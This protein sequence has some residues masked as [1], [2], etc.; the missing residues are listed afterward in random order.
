MNIKNDI[1]LSL[2]L[3]L[4]ALSTL[5][6]EVLLIRV[7]EVIFI[8]NIGY[9]VITCAMF[10]FGLAGTY[11]AIW[12]I[13]NSGNVRKRL[14]ILALSFGAAIL[15]LRPA[16]NATAI[17]YLSF[18]S[19]K[20]VGSAIR[21]S[22]VYF[23]V[24]LPFFLSGLLLAYLFSAYS[25]RIRALYF[26]DLC[27]AALGCVIYI[28]FLRAI[29]PG[30]LMFAVAAATVIAAWLFHG[31]WKSMAPALLA[32][33]ALLATPFLRGHD[34]FAFRGHQDK[35]GVLSAQLAGLDELSEWDPMSKIDIITESPTKKHV[36]YD[37]GSQ[38]SHFFKFDGDLAGLRERIL[39]GTDDLKKD[40]WEPGVLASH[41]LKR[42]SAAEVLII[43]S[44]AGQETKAA[45]VFNPASVDGIEL[46]GTVVR[47]GKEEYS[48]F[49]GGIFNDPR[50]HNQV[51]EGRQWLRSTS[52]KYD[53]IQIHSNHT[54]SFITSGVGAVSTV[55][56]QTAEA[57]REYFSHLK[58]NGILH[59]NHHFYP[60][61]ITTAALAWKQMGR[62]DFQRHVLV[63]ERQNTIDTLPT[64]LIKM[65]PWTAA[66]VA[67]V[68]H[69]FAVRDRSDPAQPNVK[70]IDPINPEASFLSSDF[71]TGALPEDLQARLDYRVSPAT[72]DR[73]YFD[74]VQVGFH[75]IK[76]DP[77][78][79]TDESM[80]SI[81]NARLKW[82]IGE[83]TVPAAI[84]L[85]GIMFAVVLVLVPLKFS[86]AGRLRWPGRLSSMAYFGCLGFGFILIELMLIQLFMKLLGYPLLAYT[87]VI[88]AILLS[89]GIGSMG[90]ERLGIEPAKRWFI[91]FFG[92]LLS[93]G[94]LLMVR[95]PLFDLL[96][97]GSTSARILATVLM[98]F[99]LGF[100]M[101]MPFPLGILHLRS[102]PD[103]AIAWAW[104][105]NGLFTV[106]GGGIAG[107]VSLF[108][109]FSVV[110]LIA[111]GVYL[112][113]LLAFAWARSRVASV[114]S[115]AIPEQP[116]EVALTA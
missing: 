76:P 105:I 35:R 94:I 64:L 12:P 80:A 57:Y 2:G 25:S 27:G 29:G 34:Y 97:A 93:G 20:I 58:D 84:G 92:I 50:V 5:M 10:G 16:L 100:F 54:T 87:S 6:A 111:M 17:I 13:G 85:L 71:F 56:L 46:V 101:G 61:L 51:G 74:S 19:H 8:N 38:S 48:D 108:T 42:D 98:I 52:R 47:L 113:A 89:A 30:G 67:A 77:A 90:A 78:R 96:L 95:T 106:L 11:A 115:P 91:P 102:A 109:G 21:G 110:F 68:E 82:P 53:I 15:L 43:G 18:S 44:A 112:M 60:R 40:F 103:G 14:T 79:F 70:V 55:Y 23:L 99:P 83:Y 45:L 1:R 75:D 26:W 66:E 36:A 24:L 22:M 107:V 4:I 3:S 33:A 41:Y 59:I 104:G 116:S 62:S 31:G 39:A 28:P 32:A 81:I 114:V 65:S 88:F 63:F 69:L 37:G 7:F 73:P 9:A 72:D 49:I 86:K